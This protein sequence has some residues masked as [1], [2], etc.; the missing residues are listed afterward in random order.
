M[1]L[2]RLR[3]PLHHTVLARAFFSTETESALSLKSWTVSQ[4]VAG[5]ASSTTETITIAP[6]GR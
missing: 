5:A 3:Q 6:D 1:L 4:R 2:G